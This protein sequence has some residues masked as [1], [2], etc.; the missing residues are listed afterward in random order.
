MNFSFTI[1]KIEAEV[2]KALSQ[3]ASVN[4][5]EKKRVREHPL[6]FLMSAKRALIL[7]IARQA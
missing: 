7:W 4:I 1:Y 6:S 5:L 2:Y 3:G